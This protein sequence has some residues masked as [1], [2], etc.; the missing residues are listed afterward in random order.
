MV[1]VKYIGEVFC[2]YNFMMLSR[3]HLGVKGA[4]RPLNF[5]ALYKYKSPQR[6]DLIFATECK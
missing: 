6:Q 5:W 2:V 3:V 4:K 1:Y